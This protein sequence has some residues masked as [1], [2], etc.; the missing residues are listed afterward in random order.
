MWFFSN[1]ILIDQLKIYG[2]M[3]YSKFRKL[4]RIVHDV[5]KAE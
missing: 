3:I 1:E 2:L 4:E 5:S